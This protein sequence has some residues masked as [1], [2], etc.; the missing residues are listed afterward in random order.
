MSKGHLLTAREAAAE[1]GVTLPTL[2][3]YVS[4]GLLRSVEDVGS[5]NKRYAWE[6][7]E[8]LRQ[9]QTLKRSPREAV[10]SALSWGIS[11]VP[12]SLTLI[13]DGRLYY[14]G[15]DAIELSRARTFAEVAG[16]LWT[17][18][19]ATSISLEGPLPS[20]AEALLKS[21]T[22]MSPIG[23]MGTILP[24]IGE[25]DLSTLDT[26][27]NVTLRTGQ[28]LVAALFRAAG[29]TSGSSAL[30]ASW[31]IPEETLQAALI[32]CADHELNASSFTA[33]CVASTGAAL[34]A[35]LSGGLAALSGPKHGR[36]SENAFALLH[37]VSASGSALNV[38][39]SR[40]RRGEAIHGFGHRLYPN[41]DPRGTRLLEMLS[42]FGSE[43]L[44]TVRAVADAAFE[45]VGEKPN[46][47]FGL[48]SLAYVLDLPDH[49]PLTIFAL[50]RSVGWIAHAREEYERNA[51][52]RPRAKY[53][54][55]RP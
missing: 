47:D 3:A 13:E 20:R 28:R 52:I 51:L 30:A 31:G 37:E 43:R 38:L 19:F 4:R 53:L 42:E 5:R 7:I 27:P 18:E 17:G 9:R 29:S 11:T 1:L 12:S 33:R 48:A 10:E 34:P 50:G 44:L 23:M 26:R 46:I 22:G 55:P 49:V 41:G 24:V 35:C 15:H 2:Y 54:G 40:M 14:R 21:L 39:S 6:D 8:R 25:D 16:L 45:I 36:S 32:I